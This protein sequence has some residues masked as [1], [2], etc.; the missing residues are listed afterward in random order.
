[1]RT[2]KSVDQPA[3][4]RS[5]VS[6]FVVLCLPLPSDNKSLSLLLV[7]VA[8]QVGL[9]LAWSETPMTKLF[10]YGIGDKNKWI[11]AFLC[12]KHQKAVV[13]GVKSDWASVVSGVPQGGLLNPLFCSLYINDISADIE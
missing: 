1:M 10:S 11:G 8:E 2:T 13:N 9:Y 4:Q 5:L 12:L 6:T 3:H 7:F